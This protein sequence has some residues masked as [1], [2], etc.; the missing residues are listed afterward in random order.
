MKTT[1]ILGAVLFAV[2]TSAQYSEAPTSTLTVVPHCASAAPDVIV[3]RSAV[4][5]VGC[6]AGN[7]TKAS[8]VSASGYGSNVTATGG[9]GSSA[10]ATT[11]SPAQ[12]TGAAGRLSVAIG[13]VGGL[14]AA[15]LLL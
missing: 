1:T 15:A 4:P 3:T 5:H 7:S 13:G 12:F 14:V 10:T 11:Y 9:S 2:G 6:A 8:I